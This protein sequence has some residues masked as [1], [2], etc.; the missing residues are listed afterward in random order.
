MATAGVLVFVLCALCTC[1]GVVGQDCSALSSSG[2]CSFY[3]D[4]VEA[5]RLACGP[6]GFSLAYG[7][8]YCERFETFSSNFNQAVSC[9]RVTLYCLIYVASVNYTINYMLSL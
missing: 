8:T 6:T 3:P 1:Q 9:Y 4:C 5:Q 2:N 7:E